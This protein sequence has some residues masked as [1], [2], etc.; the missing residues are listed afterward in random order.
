MTTD[1]HYVDM[2]IRHLLEPFE[3][4]LAELESRSLPDFDVDRVR[5][6][7]Q[8]ILSAHVHEL[9]EIEP[10]PVAHEAEHTEEHI[11]EH[12]EALEESLE[13][14][15]EELEEKIEEKIEEAIE[16]SHESPSE[17]GESNEP[18]PIPVESNPSEIERPA[19]PQR[20]NI[21][22]RKVFGGGN[23]V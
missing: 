9:P 17:E 7:A 5:A 19:P 13:E 3:K 22:T 8:E 6:I 18:V 12:I 1:F 11:E 14:K 15:I 2:H 4:R 21:L 23:N 16:E 20:N 10:A